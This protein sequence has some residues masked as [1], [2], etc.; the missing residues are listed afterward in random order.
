VSTGIFNGTAQV[1]DVL[2][3][4]ILRR[5]IASNLG[6]KSCPGKNPQ[7]WMNSRLAMTFGIQKNFLI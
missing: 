3:K 1:Q 6:L 2:A 7:E 4:S 5:V